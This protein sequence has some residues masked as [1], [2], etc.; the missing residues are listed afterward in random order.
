MKMVKRCIGIFLALA[1]VLTLAAPTSSVRAEEVTTSEITNIEV[2]M[3]GAFIEGNQEGVAL[4]WDEETQTNVVDYKCFH[5]IN[6]IDAFIITT[7]DGS[8][9]TYEDEA[10]I[11]ETYGEWPYITTDQ[12]ATNVW[13]AGTHTA[14]VS[15]QGKTF[16]FDVEVAENPIANIEVLVD[17]VLYAGAQDA[18]YYEWDDEL[19]QDVAHKEFS[20]G[21]IIS[22]I[23]V[24]TTDGV[25][26]TYADTTAM[27]DAYGEWAFI[28]TDQSADNVWGVGTHKG[29]I[30]FLG[31]TFEFGISVV[32]NP[33]ANIEVS[34]NTLYAGAQN[35]E[36][37]EWDD[38]TAQE[39]VYKYYY[40]ENYISSIKVTT[41]DGEIETYTDVYDLYNVYGGSFDIATDQ[42]AEVVWGEGIHKGTVTYL[43]KTYEFVVEVL[44]NPIADIEIAFVP[45][46]ED[47]QNS[48]EYDWN[49]ETQEE[50]LYKEFGL[51]DYISEITVTTVAGEKETYTG[52]YELKEAYG[53]WLFFETDQ[54]SENVWKAG[55]HNASAIYLGKEYTFN[56][57]VIANPIESINVLVDGVFY[58]GGQT[59]PVWEWDA[60]TEQ[61]EIA[62]KQFSMR[63]VVSGVEVTTTDGEKVVYEDLNEL[64]D[65]YNA[66][67]EFIT[68]QSAENVWNAGTHTAT[69]EFMGK[70]CEF[71]VE[72]VESPI[73]SIEAT[74]DFLYV[75]ENDIAL[76]ELM[77]SITIIEKSGTEE[78]FSHL[79]GVYEKYGEWPSLY[80]DEDT[81]EWDAGT[82]QVMIDFMGHTSAQNIEVKESPIAKMEITMKEAYIGEKV[83]ITD[84]NGEF[85]EEV[86]WA[87]DY[88]SGVKVTYTDGTVENTTV[89]E[90]QDK[91]NRWLSWTDNM[92]ETCKVGTYEVV[93][94][95]MGAKDTV[96]FVITD[97]VEQVTVVNTAETKISLNTQTDSITDAVVNNTVRESVMSA[98]TAEKVKAAVEE[99]AYVYAEVVVEEV[100]LEDVD[101]E[102]AAKIEEAAVE[103][104]GA[105][106]EVQYIDISVMLM[107]DEEELGNVHELEEEISITVGI[108]EN[109]KKDGATYCVIRNHNGVIDI[110]PATV[111]ADGTLTFTTDR[112]STYA[113]AYSTIVPEIQNP[114]TDIGTPDDPVTYYYY[115][116]VLWA[117]EKGITTGATTTTFE[118]EKACTRAQVVTFLWRTFGEPDVSGITNPFKDLDVNE[119][120]YDAVLWAVDEEITTGTTATTFE[121]E[122]T[123]TRAQFVTFLWRAAGSPAPTTTDTPFTDLDVSEYYYNA[124]LWA[125]EN[126]VT[127]GTSETT[128]EPEES[129]TR[130]QVVTF[131]YRAYA[132]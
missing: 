40:L 74:F 117:V 23:K 128:F 81:S 96:D 129:C 37:Y 30:T 51:S 78:T 57:E 55:T 126:G 28:D 17:G 79:W 89:E 98:E 122:S 94:N 120:Y 73:E 35:G 42:S 91:H 63:T 36:Y 123:V 85:I 95:F 32:E 22:G 102:A 31:K 13:T 131:L 115:T 5:P 49:E 62:Y 99:D 118:P 48:T 106:A 6:K 26:E 76:E 127:K 64:S 69:L 67:L 3:D 97:V 65:T 92:G 54:S 24:T 1:M 101:A 82:H 87:S 88:I 111:N 10:S 75:G 132:D 9:V 19:Q 104:L 112:F 86:I 15:L 125:V 53:E 34:F 71:E 107:A 38:E 80:I 84:E 61:E 103:K 21:S 50:I 27:Y 41:T 11:Y 100:S 113:I 105:E 59:Q 46:Y 114:F 45:I 47:T 39:T 8:Q 33:I 66:Y 72:V 70:T 119:Y 109:M 93:F 121:P 2:V 90:L 124:V 16:N 77:T 116:P 83:I 18:T 68:D 52:R 7:A 44:A 25:T 14:T 56:V 110:L 108:P 29:T 43:G 58:E 4:K 20:L 60:E 130:G 12:S